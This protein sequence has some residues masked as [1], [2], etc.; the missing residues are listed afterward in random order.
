MATKQAKSN[1]FHFPKFQTPES[2][3]KFHIR[4]GDVLN[5]Q[6]FREHKIG[7]AVD[8]AKAALAARTLKDANN[9]A[10]QVEAH[11]AATMDEGTNYEN[12]R[13]ALARRARVTTES[14]HQALDELRENANL[15]E[16]IANTSTEHDAE[17]IK[18]PSPST[19]G[20]AA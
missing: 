4:G 16:T 9:T 13:E 6:G 10:N 17:I 8:L 11:A 7:T 18:F 20:D 19:S 2:C 15:T 1:I 5:I 12:E 14:V 3:E